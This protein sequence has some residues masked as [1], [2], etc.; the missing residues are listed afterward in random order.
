M[1]KETGIVGLRKKA[2][3]KPEQSRTTQLCQGVSE[4]CPGYRRYCTYACGQM[5]FTWGVLMPVKALA[6]PC[7][8]K[9]KEC[10]Y[11]YYSTMST[12]VQGI[13]GIIYQYANT[14]KPY[15]VSPR[16]C[17]NITCEK[18]IIHKGNDH[19]HY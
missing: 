16:P 6:H 5:Y 8:D 11:K 2:S 10:A 3:L 1:F 4:W 9:E 14:R 12:H 13:S 18:Y 17:R 19:A 15:P 7:L